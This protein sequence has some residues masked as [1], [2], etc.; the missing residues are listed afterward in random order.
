MYVELMNTWNRRLLEVL[1]SAIKVPTIVEASAVLIF[2]QLH[3]MLPISIAPTDLPTGRG[4]W[5]GQD[6]ARGATQLRERLVQV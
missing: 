4:A 5:H 2:F 6:V 3:N 1:D